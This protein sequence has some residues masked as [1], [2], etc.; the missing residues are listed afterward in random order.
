MSVELVEQ[1]SSAAALREVREF[2]FAAR[3]T[4][5]ARV[6]KERPL[7]IASG[8]CCNFEQHGHRLYVS[9]LEAAFTLLRLDACHGI[10]L[11]ARAIDASV[12]RG[13]C[14]FLVRG[15]CGA[16]AERP[17]GCRIYFCDERARVW[18]NELYE[19]THA[20]VQALHDT[21]AIP[22]RYMEWRAALAMLRS[23]EVA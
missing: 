18:Q 21:L 15:F 2:F 14:P 20:G 9:G 3:A 17:L 12:T 10:T 1:W 16:H 8:A 13:D 6:N 4:I 7:C 19:T 5:D 22:Y 11:D 23:I